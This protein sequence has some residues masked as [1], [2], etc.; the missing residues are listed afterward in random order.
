MHNIIFN[1]HEI[2][3]NVVSIYK[4]IIEAYIGC[5]LNINMDWSQSEKNIPEKWHI[6]GHS[7]L[8]SYRILVNN[9]KFFQLENLSF[10][11]TIA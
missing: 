9:I 8:S 6:V 5:L 1:D 2:G 7:L 10:F 3:S 4:R 11:C